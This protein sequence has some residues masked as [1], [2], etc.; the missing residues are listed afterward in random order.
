MAKLSTKPT[1]IANVGINDGDYVQQRF[2]KTGKRL[3]SGKYQQ[4]S[5]WVCPYFK[6]WKGFIDRCYANSVR[7]KVT[8]YLD[9]VVSEDWKTFSNFKA[10][11]EKQDWEGK[12]LDKD[13]LSDGQ[14]I[15]SENTC[16]FI[17]PS[18][19]KFITDHKKARGAHLL[20][21]TAR[22]FGKY[23]ARCS[24]PF[25]GKY[26]ILGDF[27]NELSAHYCWLH[28]KNEHAQKL[29]KDQ[30]DCRVK[31]RLQ[32]MYLQENWIPC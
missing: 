10:W 20:G 13:F 21:V 9:V 27:D 7:N 19:N 4:K 18:L 12:H 28:K 1:M 24:N 2:E 14:K 29:A 22:P 23:R 32:K 5:V 31:S 11:M 8:T 30:Q 16:V 25:T 6:V 15:Y 17:T 3:P 26:E